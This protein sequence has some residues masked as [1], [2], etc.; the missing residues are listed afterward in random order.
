[1]CFQTIESS[2]IPQIRHEVQTTRNH[3]QIHAS[4]INVAAALISH[5]ELD[6]PIG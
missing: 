2:N 3:E 6:L 4:A 1:M 5:V